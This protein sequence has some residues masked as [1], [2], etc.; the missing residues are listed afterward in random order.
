M[1]FVSVASKGLRVYVSG[2]ES[3]LAGMPISVDSKGSYAAQKLCRRARISSDRGPGR[4]GPYGREQDR[5]KMKKREL[6]SRIPE[7]I[8]AWEVYYSD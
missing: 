2:L 7:Q 3:T 4:L 1:F 8:N 5:L 6:R